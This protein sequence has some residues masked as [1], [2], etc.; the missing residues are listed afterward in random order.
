[1]VT[2]SAKLRA[3]DAHIEQLVAS[4]HRMDL[5]M[6]EIEGCLSTVDTHYKTLHLDSLLAFRGYAEGQARSLKS[7]LLE[8]REE[9]GRLTE[10]IQE[11]DRIILGLSHELSRC[12]SDAFST[13]T[14]HQVHNFASAHA[15]THTHISLTRN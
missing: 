14:S 4:Q 13:R 7:C 5:K 9:L 1:V 2:L 6:T 8:Q 11:K 15:Q 10:T 3:A 12:E